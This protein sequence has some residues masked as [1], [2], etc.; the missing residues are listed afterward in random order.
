[1]GGVTLVGRED[2]L[3]CLFGLFL[4]RQKRTPIN[5]INITTI[6][7]F[8]YIN[9]TFKKKYT[10]NKMLKY[11][12]FID[13][14][15]DPIKTHV[16]DLFTEYFNNPVMT[17]IKDI[18]EYSMYMT[19]IHAMLGNATRYL[20]AFVSKNDLSIGKTDNLTN[21]QWVSIQTRTLEDVHKIPSHLYT[22]RKFKPFMDKIK[23]TSQD[24]EQTVYNTPNLPLI[25][26]LLHTRK[27]NVYQYQPSGTIV[28][29]LETYQTIINFK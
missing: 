27:D 15:F 19:R 12:Q 1:V 21:L 11:G 6:A 9:L 10:N 29:A 24:E 5:I 26:T 28:S 7:S 8:I 18:G 2:T 22:A 20:V 4:K 13:S 23:L 3:Y 25:V 14:G 17:K 16:Y